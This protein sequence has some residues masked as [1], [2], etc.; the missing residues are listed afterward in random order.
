MVAQLKKHP[1]K[2]VRELPIVHPPLFPHVDK[3][4]HL[5][6]HSVKLFLVRRRIHFGKRRRHL[7]SLFLGCDGVDAMARA[8][9]NFAASPPF[10]CVVEYGAGRDAPPPPPPVTLP[11]R[12]AVMGVFT[13]FPAPPFPPFPPLPPFAP[14]PLWPFIATL[15]IALP[16]PPF[17][18][19]PPPK[20]RRLG[21]TA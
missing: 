7:T 20:R 5:N 13:T 9:A 6:T 12:R 4:L 11:P 10:A 1:L 19:F 18:P 2:Q 8:V 3:L 17:P 15:R 21:E 14:L 16:F